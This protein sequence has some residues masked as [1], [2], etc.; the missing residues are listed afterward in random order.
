MKKKVY[1]ISHS[2]WDREW[3]MAYE[4][5]HMRLIELIDDLLELFEVDPSFN[6]FHLDGQTIILDD[7]LQVRPEKRQAIQQAINEGKLRIGPF[8]I[9]QDDFLISSESNVR[10]M[11][12]GMEES[13]KWGTPV[14]LGYFPDTFGNMGQ[15]P[16]LMKQAGI[17]AAA[18]GRGVKPIGFDNQV[19]EAENYSSQYSEMWWKGPDQT[20]IF[21][22]LFANWYSNGNEIPVEKEAA[23]AFW[24]QKLADAEQ[25]A[26]TNH[27]LMMN[28]VDHQPVQKD[29]SKAIHLA[30]ELFPDY[31]FIHS[32]FTDYLEAVQKD[33][34][35]DLGSVEGELTSQETDGWYTLANTASARVY[36]KQW[37]TKVQRQLENITEP[38]ATMAYEVSGNYPHDQL[39]Y[40][41]KTLMQN[42]P[43]DS[44]CG[45][46]VDSVHREMIPRFEKADEVGKY[47]AQDSLEQ[48]TAA[49]DTTGFPKDSFPFVIVNTAGMDKT[50]EAEITIELERKRFAEGIP[51]QLYQEL[52][53][54]P[55]RKYHVET[56]SGATIPAILSEETV[57]FGYDLPKDRFRVPYMARMIKVTLPLENMPAFS[58]ET[59]A[60]VEGEAKAEEKETM[61][62]QSGR[63]IENGPLHLTIEKNGAITMEDRKNKRKLNNLHIFEDIGDIGNEYIFKQPFCDQPI[64]SS[65]KENSEVKVLVDTPEIAKISIL[66]E[67]EIP[68]SADER[69]EKEQQMVVE[70]RYRKAERSKEKR[71]L[72]I[73]T[74]MTI[75]KDS[76]KID[77][78]TTLDNQMKDHRLRVLFPTKLHVEHHEADSIFEVVKRPNHVSKSWENP[79]NPQ[80]QQAFVNIHDEEYGV[81]VGNFG[82]N[83][84]EVTEDGQIAVTLLRSVGELGDW[85]YFPTPEAQCLGEHRFNY[86]IE[87]H[88]PEEKFSTYLHAYAAQ[89]P[90]STQQIKHHEGTLISKQQYLTIKSETFAITALKRS[91]F[92]DKVVVRGFNMSSHLEKLE[93]TKDNGKTVILNLL[94]EP[95]KQAVVPIIQPYEI[96]T[97]GFEEENECMAE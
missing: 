63:I 79:T 14:M 1:I 52:E 3:Y 46:S 83:E 40:A 10:N 27:L 49:I 12:I 25:Y 29:I 32:N 22:L 20:A 90:F 19:L 54:L 78:E 86:S 21:G 93:I 58:W 44:I 43:H 82:L 31:E 64:L 70:F 59:F 28:G 42:H 9:L 38:L 48:L 68:V 36:L 51:E 13:R 75:R 50:G 55:K 18:F 67:M 91:K 81:T 30:N 88:G 23:L 97:I 65:N 73:K 33:V 61:I 6:S 26:S 2:H 16:Q 60:L 17:S 85:G 57:Q 39:D 35:E 47:L 34:P 71:I 72:Q 37:N 84:Y 87:L 5:H 80:H 77:F 8:Y 41:W 66:Q 95:T 24:K 92:S 89:I 96:R 45:C 62:H 15:T 56:K 69:L 53:N 74:I 94:E 7:Y 4:Q 76:K 11:L